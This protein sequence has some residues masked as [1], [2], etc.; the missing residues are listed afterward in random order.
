VTGDQ[1]P[2]HLF[3]YG[4]LMRGSRSPY[5]QLLRVR[6]RYIGEGSAAGRLYSL[7]PFPGAVFEEAGQGRVHGEVFRL[8]GPK[9]LQALDTYEGCDGQGTKTGNFQRTTVNVALAKGGVLPAWTYVFTGPVNGR[10]L[11]ASGRFVLR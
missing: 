6:A 9:L 5:A 4:T 2:A 1:E 10:P 11:I 3:V 7:G 8:N